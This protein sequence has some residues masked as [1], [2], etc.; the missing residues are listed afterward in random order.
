MNFVAETRCTSL[1]A[2]NRSCSRWR[3]CGWEEAKHVKSAR[4]T[5]R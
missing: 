1:Q 5:K 4:L 2:K 3:N